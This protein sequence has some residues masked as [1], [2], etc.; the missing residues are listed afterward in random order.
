MA[1]QEAH[2]SAET[3]ASADEEP[4]RRDWPHLLHGLAAVEHLLRV[5]PP[6]IPLAPHPPGVEGEGVEDHDEG[7]EAAVCRMILQLR[8]CVGVTN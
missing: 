3:R 2:T 1:W 5:P 7:A 8:V 4:R 6:R